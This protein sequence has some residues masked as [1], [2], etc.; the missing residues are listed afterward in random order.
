MNIRSTLGY[1]G[2]ILGYIES[3]LGYIGSHLVCIESTLGYIGNTFGLD[4]LAL[5]RVMFGV[6]W[7]ILSFRVF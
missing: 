2:S 4:L 6:L 1:F 3:T 5:Y 7:H